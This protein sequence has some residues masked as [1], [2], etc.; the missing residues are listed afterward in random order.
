MKTT[1]S[2]IRL[3][4][5]YLSEDVAPDFKFQQTLSRATQLI[6]NG[7]PAQI[8]RCI[9][10]GTKNNCIY[11]ETLFELFDVLVEKGNESQ[12]KTAGNLICNEYVT[13]TRDAKDTQTNLRRKLGRI[14]GKVTNKVYDNVQD[15][16]DT[17]KGA[18]NGSKKNFVNNTNQIKSAVSSATGKGKPVSKEEKKQKAVEEA[19]VKMEAMATRMYQADRMI[20]NYDKFSKRFN[21]D[22]LIQENVYV[23]GI[24]DTVVSICGFMETYNIPDE[25]KFSMVMENCWYGF[26]KNAVEFNESDIATTATDYY[27]TKGNNN[28]MC[29]K[30]LENSL[31]VD[32]DDYNGDLELIQEEE[33][34]DDDIKFEGG[35]I[36][37]GSS[38]IVRALTEIDSA[39][40]KEPT[41]DF[42]K[43]L[44][45]YKASD[46]DKKENK[47]QY[48][49]RKLYTKKP[50]QIIEGTPSVF[51]YIRKFFV[52]GI[53]AINPVLAAVALMADI[54]AGLHM[55][56]EEAKKILAHY[57]N[58]IKIT[59]KKLETTKD[60]N[61]KERL[62]AYL[63]AL[64]DAKK[65][66]NDYYESLLSD[67]ELDKKYEEDNDSD[68]DDFDFGDDFDLEDFA[69]NISDDD[70]FDFD[71]GDDDDF[72]FDDFEEA[73]KMIPR[74]GIMMS[75]RESYES[76]T[77]TRE[78]CDRILLNVPSLAE[79]FVEIAKS[80]YNIIDPD[81]LTESL[82][83]I[84]TKIE[85][86]SISFTL[87]ERFTIKNALHD[88]SGYTKPEKKQFDIFREAKEL[89]IGN[90]IIRTLNT[91][92]NECVYKS[93]ITEASFANSVNLALQKLKKDAVK[94]SDKEKTI[95]KT[96]DVTANNMTK[97]VERSLTNDNREAIIKGSILP[98]ASKIV[99]AA[100]GAAGT[101]VLIDPV[102]AIIGV[103]GWLGVSK[104]YKAKE[105]QMVIDELE[106]E[107]KICEKQIDI[108]ERNEDMQALRQLYRIQKELERQRQRIKYKMRVEYGQKYHD[109]TET[110]RDMN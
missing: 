45:N 36:F 49:I 76:S 18:I 69:K 53:C 9:E 55:E 41:S 103:L 25:Q 70:D 74:V 54:L 23:N 56:R 43:E 90:S 40:K 64:K 60:S 67:E 34:E 100:I 83:S 97:A 44:N 8:I 80:S 16:M 91:L 102:I 35:A 24:D 31:V 52:L 47:L 73:V 79:T 27:L 5:K 46:D 93:P 58:E 109:T 101:A 63:K 48:L 33:P 59:K 81:M 105:R 72:D 10:F 65:K 62:E 6:E 92:N 42:M 37:T 86:K 22:K 57:D 51:G 28:A 85:I 17:I 87:L 110:L 106:T 77:L 2:D 104:K 99:K 19:Y 30:I 3:R 71:F 1:I 66:V 12:I 96:I 29:K 98:S 38:S 89:S 94:L 14:T 78:M 75:L 7:S 95:S 68:D 4:L 84:A 13:K 88:I 26:H 107:L 32:K 39:V 20:K 11:E 21:I 82:S 15:A 108:A 61:E 50:E